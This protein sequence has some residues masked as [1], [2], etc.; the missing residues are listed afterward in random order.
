MSP[1][2]KVLS[3][4]PGLT[5]QNLG[6]SGSS[7]PDG[8]ESASIGFSG[9]V[10]GPGEPAALSTEFL[11]YLLPEQN[12]AALHELALC[13]FPWLRLEPIVD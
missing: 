8:L 1:E 9:P 5:L 12:R 2:G 3:P 11:E 4:L 7:R 10:H 13:A 6:Q